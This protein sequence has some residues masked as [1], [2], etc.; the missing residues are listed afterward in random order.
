MF[1]F[2]TKNDELKKSL[3]EQAERELKA[4]KDQITALKELIE[5]SNESFEEKTLT[6]EHK[7]LTIE[8]VNHKLTP[9]IEKLQAEKDEL[10]KRFNTLEAD[11]LEIVDN[12]QQLWEEYQKL[13]ALRS[14]FDP[15]LKDRASQL[16]VEKDELQERF[17]AL[18]ADR[19]EIVKNR[20]FLWEEYQK[21]EISRNDWQERFH[22]IEQEISELRAQGLSALVASGANVDG[23]TVDIERILEGSRL[24]QMQIESLDQ[25]NNF[26][27][28]QIRQN[29]DEIEKF[30]KENK[31]I[32]D[33]NYSLDA[34]W[35]RLEQ[36]FPNYIDYG[37]LE[38]IS[39]DG[40]AA[41]PKI[42]WKITDYSKAGFSLP[43]FYFQTILQNG[44][45]GIAMINGD[46]EG[47]SSQI[48]FPGLLSQSQQQR[49]IFIEY[50]LSE[51]HKLSAACD[52]LE[53]LIV[54]KGVGL[55]Q[56]EGF[57]LSFWKNSLATLIQSIQK[58]PK[59]LRFDRV[60]VKR[61]LINPNYEHLWLEFYNVELGEYRLPKFEM[62]ISAA[63][64]QPEG[65]S[66]F[67]KIEIPLIDG[68]TKPFESWYP[69][70]HD[71][72]G[73]KLELRFSLDKNVFDFE[74]FAKLSALDQYFIQSFIYRMPVILNLLA[75]NKVS[76]HRPW[77]DWQEFA[78]ATAQV[79]K[80]QLDQIRAIKK[81]DEA[82][83]NA[84]TTAADNIL[85][86]QKIK[87]PTSAVT[88]TK[89]GVSSSPQ[90]AVVRSKKPI[91]AKKKT[92]SR[93]AK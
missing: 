89:K 64:V 51:W 73:A 39:V 13:D 47:I 24:S 38:L 40:V 14:S 63:L 29:Q 2:L 45:A 34:K 10:Q 54:N 93:L 26:L 70:S 87:S 7:L 3:A 85:Q 12:R 74:V 82:K 86:D 41:A 53:Q 30:S 92:A 68:K 69:E 59:I 88:V 5:K 17:N 49:D 44:Q 42:V 11:R 66:R 36:R 71:D 90:K 61:E 6:Y 8:A 78:K 56:V 31:V 43:E 79:M 72:Q 28:I 46:D 37:G 32:K 16:Q 58:L 52:V 60:R 65:F 25:E 57:D 33:L 19:S 35:R 21:L 67:P 50:G 48:L 91:A 22:K 76:I 62:R 15:S 23:E 75:K 77:Q 4:L 83:V 1:G 80:A 81:A 20:Q 27:L 84:N 55:G 9:E 18:E